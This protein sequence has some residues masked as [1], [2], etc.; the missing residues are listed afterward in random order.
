MKISRSKIKQPKVEESQILEHNEI[1]LAGFP[2]WKFCSGCNTF[3]RLDGVMVRAAVEGDY[4][5]QLERTLTES[6]APDWALIRLARFLT[7]GGMDS[8]ILQGIPGRLDPDSFSE[9]LVDVDRRWP[10]ALWLTEAVDKVIGAEQT[11]GI[12][13]GITTFERTPGGNQEEN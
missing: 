5:Q 2:V 6:E 13:V 9:V 11:T 10:P 7:P 4:I 1:L 3:V 12:R 8:S